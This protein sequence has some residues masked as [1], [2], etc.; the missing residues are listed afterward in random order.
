MYRI[1]ERGAP[2]SLEHRIFF[3][4]FAYVTII[5]LSPYLGRDNEL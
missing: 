5:A 2:N 3:R 4:E 1:E